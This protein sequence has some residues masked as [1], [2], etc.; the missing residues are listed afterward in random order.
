MKNFFEGNEVLV[1][2][3]SE[4][5]SACLD[6]EGGAFFLAWSSELI[7]DLTVEGYVR[8]ATLATQK[9]CEAVGVDVPQDCAE[10]AEK[11]ETLVQISLFAEA[12][13]DC[14]TADMGQ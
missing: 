10:S 8:S 1:N 12:L 11:A 6:M 4:V 5:A 7:R 2:S 13:S 14:V 3:A 9:L